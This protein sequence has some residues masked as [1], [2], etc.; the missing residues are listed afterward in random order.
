LFSNPPSG[1]LAVG[2]RLQGCGILRA[3]DE[4]HPK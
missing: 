4:K 2:R 1:S 3:F